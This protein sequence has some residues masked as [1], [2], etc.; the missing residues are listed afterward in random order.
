MSH[1]LERQPAELDSSLLIA[2]VSHGR[3][4]AMV[5]AMEQA[6]TIVA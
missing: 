1:R 5:V 3:R 6:M 4:E 2:K